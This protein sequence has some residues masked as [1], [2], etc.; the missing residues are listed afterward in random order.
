LRSLEEKM[1]AIIDTG[2]LIEI[3]EGSEIGKKLL[4]LII[5]DKIEPMITDITLIESTY[6]L[7]RKSGMEKLRN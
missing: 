6:I 5:N 1:R 2:L 3:F 4:D 7:C